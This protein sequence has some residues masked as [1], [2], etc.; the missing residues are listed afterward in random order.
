MKLSP[1][2]QY[3]FTLVCRSEMRKT[4]FKRET[5]MDPKQIDNILK[6]LNSRRL[7]KAIKLNGKK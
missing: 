1:D 7:I 2:E 3:F 6:E 4:D 5:K